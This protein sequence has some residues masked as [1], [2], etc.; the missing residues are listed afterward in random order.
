MYMTLTQYKWRLVFF[1]SHF[2]YFSFDFL[3]LNHLI[4]FYMYIDN[5]VISWSRDWHFRVDYKFLGQFMHI[6]TILQPKMEKMYH[7]ADTPI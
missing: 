7:K 4:P 2:E 5:S 6:F 3:Y 1:G